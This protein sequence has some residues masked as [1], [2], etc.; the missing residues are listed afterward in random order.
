MIAQVTV[1][2]EKSETPYGAS[3]GYPLYAWMLSMVSCE[4]GERLHE[5]G[6]HPIS[7]HIRHDF[8]TQE[9]WWIVNLLN[10]E[11]IA[12]FLPI[13]ERAQEAALHHKTIRFVQKKTEQIG[14]AQ[15]FIE[16]ARLLPDT[17]RYEFQFSAPTSF[18][19]DGRYVIF[20]QE[21]LLLQ[22][23]VSRWNLCFPEIELDDPEAM[24]AILR[25]LRITDYKLQTLRHPVKQARI[26]SFIGKLILET[27]LPAPLAEVFKTLYCFSP[28]SGVGIKTTLGMGGVQIRP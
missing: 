3:L 5:Q 6:I 1:Q 22:S 15:A 12:L 28:Y 21:S 27:R 25:G 4:D 19:Q 14:S 24:Q 17:N 2:L 9:D 13:L 8:K 23:L 20:P 16:R 11:A 10:D 26:P 7:Q 18:K